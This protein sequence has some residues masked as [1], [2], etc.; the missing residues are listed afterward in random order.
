MIF[1]LDVSA[2][3]SSGKLFFLENVNAKDSAATKEVCSITLYS[4][5][6]LIPLFQRG[7]DISIQ[8]H[9]PSQTPVWEGPI[10]TSFCLPNWSLVSREE[11][12]RHSPKRGIFQFRILT[13]HFQILVFHFQILVFHF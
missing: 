8:N 4:Q 3:F 2:E 10:I 11:V 13:F 7:G 1:F 12:L 6:P 5:T 9:T